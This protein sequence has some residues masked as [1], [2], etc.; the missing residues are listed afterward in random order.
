M[1]VLKE[2]I[3]NDLP[4][5]L[6]LFHKNKSSAGYNEVFT[7]LNNG[8][9]Y[10]YLNHSMKKLMGIALCK[11]FQ[12]KLAIQIPLLLD[13]MESLDTANIKKIDVDFIGFGVAR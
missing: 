3:K 13:D 4:F 5:E 2:L 10:K 7:L 12:T 11:F 6:K 9:D 1:Q 8:V